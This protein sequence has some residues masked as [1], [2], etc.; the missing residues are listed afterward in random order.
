MLSYHLTTRAGY[1]ISG[2]IVAGL[3]CDTQAAISAVKPR[4]IN[5]KTFCQV[6]ER[7]SDNVKEIKEALTEGPTLNLALSI[8]PI[9]GPPCKIQRKT[10]IVAIATMAV[11]NPSSNREFFQGNDLQGR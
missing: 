8:A 1:F 9:R 11:L 2:M 3:E 7:F 6:F 10:K 5:L 4:D